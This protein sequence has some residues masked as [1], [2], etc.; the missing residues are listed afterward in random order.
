M[1]RRAGAAFKKTARP[2]RREVKGGL[3]SLAVLAA[4]GTALLGACGVLDG[5]SE[6]VYTPGSGQPPAGQRGGDMATAQ[7]PVAPNRELPGRRGGGAGEGA[8]E[9][10]VDEGSGT[11]QP[12][13]AVYPLFAG[14]EG[15]PQSL[16]VNDRL[17]DRPEDAEWL[18]R[19]ERTGLDVCVARGL[20]Q[21]GV[22]S[23]V[24]PIDPSLPVQTFVDALDG[25]RPRFEDLADA[26]FAQIVSSGGLVNYARISSGG[27]L[28]SAWKS[29]AGALAGLK[30]E[31]ADPDAVKVA[32]WVNAYNVLMIDALVEGEKIASP[33]QRSLVFSRKKRAVAGTSLTLDQ[34][35]YGILKLGSRSVSVTELDNAL[36][37]AR[38][39]PSLHVALVCGALS[40]PKLR[41]F[42][43]RAETINQIL[44]ENLYM[45]F[46]DSKKHFVLE[47]DTYR[48]SSLLSF[49]TGDF[50]ALAGE[51]KSFLPRRFVLPECRSD[52]DAL[53]DAFRN[54]QSVGELA[55]L[56]YD[57]SVNAQ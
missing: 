42:A 6:T 16:N 20:A 21:F 27:D 39:Y 23:I 17:A 38:K 22:D 35:E 41:P 15:A 7:P 50:D 43:Y 34:I 33:I 57:W 56:T 11:V 40:C 5:L 2:S 28:A 36:F 45:F 30:P 4:A 1:A 52:G 25:S 19:L 47:G 3:F 12:E 53:A 32:F 8:G 44:E 55:F 18:A 26:L 10:A 29:L 9:G 48:V 31:P 14:V 37:P 13:N 51:D 24:P 49:F 46:N 54:V